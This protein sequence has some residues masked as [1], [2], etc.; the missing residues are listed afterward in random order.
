MVAIVAVA[1]F[2]ALGAVARYQFDGFVQNHVHGV[3]PLGTLTINIIG[4]LMLGVLVGLNIRYGLSDAIELAAGTGFVVD[5]PRFPASCTR[6]L[7]C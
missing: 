4:S 2:G 7:T 3:M 5:L 1:I 6:A